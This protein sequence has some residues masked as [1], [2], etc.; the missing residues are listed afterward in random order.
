MAVSGSAIVA[1]AKKLLGDPYVYGGTSP[2]GFDCSGLVQYVFNELGVS[3]PRTSSAQY[4]AVTHISA[5]PSSPPPIGSLVFAN[6]PGIDTGPSPGHVGIYVGGGQVLSAE[7][8]ASGVGLSSL[9][10][11]GSNIVGYGQAPGT[12][13]GGT[14]QGI[15][16]NVPGVSAA[17]STASGAVSGSSSTTG[18]TN[19][20]PDPLGVSKLLAPVTGL[21]KD[22]AVAL[23]YILGMF[24]RGQGWRLVFTALMVAA[25]VGAWKCL[26][27]VGMVPDV[28]VPK[29]IPA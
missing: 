25:G 16:G 15:Q 18:T 1:A 8:P 11:W 21:V 22:M 13:A 29:V 9:A 7:D 20:A 10:S 12:S 2:S 28:S 4:A 5:S 24:G 3:L 19:T 17:G 14:V 6:F 23:D 27:A 26:A